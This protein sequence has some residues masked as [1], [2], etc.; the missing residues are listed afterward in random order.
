MLTNH[1]VAVQTFEPGP[2]VAYTIET[3]SRITQIPRHTIA[4]YC[5][6]GLVSPVTDPKSGGWFFD[7]QAIRTLRQIEQLRA[8]HG[9][10]LEAIALII[11]LMRHVQDLEKRL[12]ILRL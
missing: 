10:N 6:H 1:E 9:A 4:V 11:G 12:R 5:R 8:A 3:V 7:D 2:D